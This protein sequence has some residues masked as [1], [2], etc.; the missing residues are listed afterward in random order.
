MF[1]HLNLETKIVCLIILTIGFQQFPVIRVGG[2]F[3]IYELFAIALL[4]ISLFSLRQ[5][6]FVTMLKFYAFGFFVLS[7][8]ISLLLSYLFLDYPS[9]FY[10]KYLAASSFKFNYWIFPALQLMYMF[11]NYVVYYSITEAKKLFEVFDKVLIALIWIGTGIALYSLFAMFIVDVISKLPEF[12]QNKQEFKFRSTGLSQEPSFYVLFQTWIVLIIFYAKKLFSKTTWIGLFT[13]NLISLVFTF[14][15]TLVA[16]ILII[17]LSFFILKNPIKIKLT[18]LAGIVVLSLVVYVI[19]LNSSNWNYI[20]TFFINKLTNFFSAPRHTMD[21][22]SF[23]SYTTRIGLAIFKDFPFFGVGVGNSIY[24]MYIYEHKMGILVFGEKLFAGSFPQNSF[25]IVLSEQGILGGLFFAALLGKM[26][27]E[28]WKYRNRDEFS[29][30][31]FIGYLFNIAA[32]MTIAPVY[33]LF[34]WVFPAVGMGYINY[35]FKSNYEL[36]HQVG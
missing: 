28:F 30:M 15:T 26:F 7:P 2:S 31:F 21:S 3:K 12:L 27:L 6:R 9:G 36:E 14:S 19:L 20:E 11:F 10:N 22:G 16:L 25:S 35:N 17:G 8:A 13:V 29:R 23:R 33:S 34:I 5:I 18:L 32:L 24:Y 4:M 1:K